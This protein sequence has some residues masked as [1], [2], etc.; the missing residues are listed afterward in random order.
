MIIKHNT[1]YY[2]NN[3]VIFALNIVYIYKLLIKW[4]N[5]FKLNN[6]GGLI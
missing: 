5:L 3:L 6:K 4:Y 1:N 2:Y